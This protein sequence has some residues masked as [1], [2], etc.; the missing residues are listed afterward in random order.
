MEIWTDGSIRPD[1]ALETPRR[2]SGASAG[3]LAGTGRKG[4]PR[5]DERRRFEDL[6]LLSPWNFDLSFGR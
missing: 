6:K 3:F 1:A 2:F 4:C 5:S